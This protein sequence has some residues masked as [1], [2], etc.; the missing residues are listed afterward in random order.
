MKKMF[1]GALLLM[2]GIIGML[3]FISLSVIHP[4]SYD[5]YTGLLGFLL[6]TKTVWVFALFCIMFIIGI[7]I[8]FY[9]AYIR[10]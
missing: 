9:E 2:C 4:W 6:G 7:T 8:C 1:F 10:K 5:N 3:V